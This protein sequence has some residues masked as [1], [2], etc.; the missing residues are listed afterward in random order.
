MGYTVLAWLGSLGLA[1]ALSYGLFTLVD[2][3][4]LG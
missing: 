1:F 4:L 3:L 2:R